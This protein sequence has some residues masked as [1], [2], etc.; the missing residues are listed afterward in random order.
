MIGTVA[1]LVA[2]VAWTTAAG[3]ALIIFFLGWVGSAVLR[4]F[5]ERRWARRE[6]LSHSSIRPT[7]RTLVARS[8]AFVVCGLVG[9]VAASQIA[10]PAYAVYPG[11]ILGGTVG[12]F[13]VIYVALMRSRNQL[14]DQPRVP[15]VS[16]T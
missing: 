13:A 16:G 4:G 10:K 3:W 7:K 8:I 1:A 11:F 6:L 9:A 15:P 5:I 14:R 12:A 2:T